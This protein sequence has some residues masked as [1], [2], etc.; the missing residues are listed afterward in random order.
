MGKPKALQ[1][2]KGGAAQSKTKAKNSAKLAKKQANNQPKPS[3]QEEHEPEVEDDDVHAEDLHFFKKNLNFL[4]TFSAVNIVEENKETLRQEKK[5]R[6]AEAEAREAG[7]VEGQYE[8]T[9]V[10]EDLTEKQIVRKEKQNKKELAGPLPVKTTSGELHFPKQSASSRKGEEEEAED[11]ED[12]EPRVEL[13]PQ[14]RKKPKQEKQKGAVNA[15]A[16]QKEIDAAEEEDEEDDEDDW[17]NFDPRAAAAKASAD[18]RQ[19]LQ[20][21]QVVEERRQEMKMTIAV[22][23]YTILQGPEGNVGKIKEI[24]PLCADE[25]EMVAQL[26]MLSLLAVYKDIAPSYR[27]RLPTEKE[28]EVKV[29]K[30]V[31]KVRDY[32]SALL[33]SY[34]AYL[35]VLFQASSIKGEGGVGLSLRATAAVKCM[36]G[37]MAALPHFNY[38]TDLLSAVLP[39]ACDAHLEVNKMCCDSLADMFR[40]DR[41]GESALQAV[42]MIAG[43]V[44]KRKCQVPA[45][46][47]AVFLVLKFDADL[48]RRLESEGDAVDPRK[49]G[50]RAKDKKKKKKEEDEKDDVDEDMLEAEARLD[51][52]KRR[53]TQTETLEAIFEVY[54]RIVK[55]VDEQSKVL[56]PTVF[57]GLGKLSH[58]IS[59]DFLEDLLAVLQKVLTRDELS[60]EMR[61]QGVLAACDVLSGQTPDPPSYILGDRQTLQPGRLA[62]FIK[63]MAGAALHCGVGECMGF[64]ALIRLIFMRNPTLRASLENEGCLPGVYRPEM[65]TP[66]QSGAQSVLLWDLSLLQNHWHGGVAELARQLANTPLDGTLHTTG[67]TKPEVLQATFSTKRGGFN[68]SIPVPKKRRTAAGAGG[69]SKAWVRECLAGPAYAPFGEAVPAETWGDSS[70]DQSGLAGDDLGLL[71]VDVPRGPGLPGEQPAAS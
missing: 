63:R 64:L 8:R 58:L 23:G 7:D 34:Q 17:D 32:E 26:A 48:R 68:P 13:G 42:E 30:D 14:N 61:A 57:A 18:A 28:L 10:P 66:D 52:V 45:Q 71:A 11:D 44:K 43:E 27:I 33:K 39:M 40:E 38:F 1:S 47:V 36:C 19:S 12:E 60:L 20:S 31:A 50:K 59:V 6:R 3:N 55:Y 16:K 2:K 53:A 24:L 67:P 46:L 41:S 9:H 4:P 70:A 25:D 35:R 15:A 5:R 65:P 69:T 56:L 62:A 51:P 37:L 21:M 22:A 49:R 29:S 54:F